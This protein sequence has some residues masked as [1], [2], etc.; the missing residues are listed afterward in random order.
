MKFAALTVFVAAVVATEGETCD[1]ATV[2][3]VCTEECAC[4]GFKTDAADVTRVC[5]G[6][7]EASPSDIEDPVFFSCAVPAVAEV[8]GTELTALYMA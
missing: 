4:C 6:A 3:D 7:A 1:D 5:S 2:A 8:G